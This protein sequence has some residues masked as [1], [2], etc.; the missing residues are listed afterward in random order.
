[1]SY[2]L[3]IKNQAVFGFGVKAI[4]LELSTP[5][6]CACFVLLK[7]GMER[8]MLWKANQILLVHTFHIRSMIEC[9]MWYE[10][11]HNWGHIWANMPLGNF[12]TLYLSLVS[13]TFMMTP[14]WGWKKTQQLFNPVDWNHQEAATEQTVTVQNGEVKKM[15]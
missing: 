1:M 3:A 8:S 7:M 11:Y 15:I 4:T 6:S 9:Y 10:T 12:V 5:F 13:V 14:Y 2:T